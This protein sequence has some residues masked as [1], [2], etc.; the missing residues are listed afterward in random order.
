MVAQAG[1]GTTGPGTLWVPN[2]TRLRHNGS[3][4]NDFVL[5]FAPKGL[6]KSAQGNALGH[7]NHRSVLALKGRY[8]R[9][10]FVILP[11]VSPFQGCPVKAASWSQGVALG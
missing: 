6:N 3:A 4:A 10:G 9:S 8:K 5:L 2:G 7:G 11:I 1:E